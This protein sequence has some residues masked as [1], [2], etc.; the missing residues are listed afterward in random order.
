MC[1]RTHLQTNTHTDTEKYTYANTHTHTH[2]HTD[3]LISGA[4]PIVWGAAACIYLW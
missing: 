1:T 3:I 2:I 4:V